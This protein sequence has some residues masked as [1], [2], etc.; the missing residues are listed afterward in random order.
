MTSIAIKAA[1][2]ATVDDLHEGAQFGH[3]SA[4]RES[5][6]KHAAAAM[7]ALGEAEIAAS[8]DWSLVVE[9]SGGMVQSIVSNIWP[10]PVPVGV[11][12]VDYDTEGADET[13]ALPMLDGSDGD[14]VTVNEFGVTKATV[15]DIE[16]IYTALY[17]DDEAEEIAGVC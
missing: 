12:G 6:R 3:S 8:K 15:I 4:F 10:L 16:A 11:L 1:L 13:L 9:I 7:Q 2:L 14:D 17:P 5:C